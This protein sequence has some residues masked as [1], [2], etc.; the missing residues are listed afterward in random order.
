MS[1]GIGP[2]NSSKNQGLT[3]ALLMFCIASIMVRSEDRP[4]PGITE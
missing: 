2:T 3:I 4:R 1:N